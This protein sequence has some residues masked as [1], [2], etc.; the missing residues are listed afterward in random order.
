MKF[1]IKRVSEVI[2]RELGD[3]IP[4]EVKFKAKLVTVQ[5]VDLT[6]D[7]K[8]CH[9]YVSAIGTKEEQHEAIAALVG[10]RKEL[11]KALSRRVIIKY[12][13]HLHFE[14]DD[15]IVRGNRVI[16]ILQQIEPTLPSMVE[17][18]TAA[19]SAEEELSDFE[20]D[21]EEVSPKPRRAKSN[22]RHTTTE[23]DE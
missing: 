16:D 1:R 15:S 14:L 6:P 8:Q 22:R 21:E 9:V 23:D 18:E 11:Q 20:E 7:L 12:T 10:H 5:H 17:E 2:K 19:E 13:P 3:I 4:K